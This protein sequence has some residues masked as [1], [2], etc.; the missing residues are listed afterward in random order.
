[1]SN[2]ED[3][4]IPV[5]PR[6]GRPAGYA[7]VTVSTS[8]D[9]DR[10]ISQLSGTEIFERKV[11]IQRARAGDTEAPKSGNTAA[12]EVAST[13]DE[14]HREGFH[15]NRSAKAK[16]KREESDVL[17]ESSENTSPREVQAAAPVNWNAVN[18]TKIRTSLGGSIGKVK[19]LIDQS[20]PT[21][22]GGEKEEEPSDR[23]VG[24]LAPVQSLIVN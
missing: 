23:D 24:E 21:N 15:S 14:K 18:T 22:G 5:N 11:S 20:T 3:V 19:D 9:A 1:M 2:R 17:Q 7:F 12:K 16:D 8:H 13:P 10:A 6:T 4:T